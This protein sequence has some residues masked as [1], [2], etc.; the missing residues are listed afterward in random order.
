MVLNQS[1]SLYKESFD[2]LDKQALKCLRLPRN[3]W[4]GK[5]LALSLTGCEHWYRCGR[6]QQLPFSLV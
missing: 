6:N 5:L 4:H 3:S 2:E 1:R